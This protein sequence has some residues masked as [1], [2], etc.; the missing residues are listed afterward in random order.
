MSENQVSQENVETFN[1]QAEVP[2]VMS[3]IINS[4][5]SSKEM[6][7][8][9][10]ISNSSDAI[11]K[12]IAKKSEFEDQGY[13]IDHSGSFKITVIPDKKNNTLTIKD[14]G[15]GMTK[16]DL[17]SFLGS[18]AT[19][20]TQKFKSFLSNKNDKT[21]LDSLIGQFGLGFYSGFLV[22]DKIDVIT[23]HPMDEGYI[24]SSKCGESA[25]NVAKFNVGDIN[26][27]TSVILHLKEGEHEYLESGKLI[28]L[29][30]K[31][32]FYIKYPVSVMVEKE[33]KKEEEK[34]KEIEG[35][36]NVEEVK[37]DGENPKEEVKETYME[38]QKVNSEVSVWGQKLDKIPEEDLKKFYKSI[39]NDYDDYLA[40]QSWHYEG[41]ID[42][43]ILLFIPKKAKLGFFETDKDKNKN[44]K[45]F[46]SNVFVTDDLGKNVVPDWMNFIVGAV[47]SSDFPMNISREFLQGKSIMNLLK[48]KLPKCIAEMIR[49]LQNDKEKFDT[50]YREFAQ[51]IKLAVRHYSDNEQEEFSKFLRY[52]TNKDT[53]TL[54]SLDE[55]LEKIPEN[56]KQILYLTGLNKQ[57]VENSLYLEGF[58]DKLVLLMS[59]SVDEF[60]LQG[61]KNYKGLE[62]QNISMEG[63]ES[64][65]P[66]SEEQIKEF[67]EFTEKIKT[68]LSDKIEKV[69]ISNRF[70]DVV[71]TILV[72]KYGASATLE[73][74]LK[75]QPGAD[76]NPMFQMMF[77]GKKIL[78]INIDNPVVQRIKSLFDRGEEEDFTNYV[79]FLYSYAL[80]GAGYNLEDKF[81][82][83]KSLNSI[84]FEAV[85][86]K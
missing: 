38:E 70:A 68:I 58:K 13:S 26:H 31:H 69:V 25:F 1:F 43:K 41:V 39:S 18:I 64:N 45:V 23:K 81:A 42:L 36:E 52:P 55:Y 3:L 51:Y 20:G 4:V 27:G 5:Y 60:M 24:W 54:I 80:I 10:L 33:V 50:F 15:I 76:N 57:D 82:F 21:N 34:V 35:E 83:I 79:K 77:K 17:I 6:F 61:F 9:E 29:I 84:L 86:S 72:P 19:S 71:S 40:V 74:I 73:A 59:E 53:K 48:S 49:K 47:S 7:L 8:R 16:A 14:N 67:S 11:S 37:E 78:E 66:L 30:K 32:S 28:S 63:A 62:L 12:I 85:S 44:I 46:N 56:S 65:E 2:Q 22:A 75:A